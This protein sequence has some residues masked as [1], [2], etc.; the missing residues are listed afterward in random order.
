MIAA[1][2]PSPAPAWVN[3][4]RHAGHKGTYFARFPEKRASLRGCSLRAGSALP[5]GS[6][7]Q[8]S[9]PA[10]DGLRLTGLPQPGRQR[11]PA[12]AGLQPVP[13]PQPQPRRAR[14]CTSGC[15]CPRKG[16]K[17]D[18]WCSYVF[19]DTMSPPLATAFNTQENQAGAGV[20]SRGPAAPGGGFSAVELP[21]KHPCGSPQ[22]L[23]LLAKHPVSVF[24]GGLAIPHPLRSGE[25]VAG[26]RNMP[27]SCSHLVTIN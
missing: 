19:Q 21:G 20:G 24:H 25:P 2:S 23:S 10:T 22:C 3:D 11:C 5:P 14:G 13:V 6:W 16:S 8:P 1:P 9:L 15:H 27:G 4:H 18:V 12:P 17:D 26:D 7:E